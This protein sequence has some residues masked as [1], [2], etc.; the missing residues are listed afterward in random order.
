[1]AFRGEMELTFFWGSSMSQSVQDTKTWFVFLW[2]NVLKEETELALVAHAFN[3]SYSGGGDQEDCNS[4]PA[5]ANSSR[6]TLHKNR[7]GGVAEGEG[8]EFKP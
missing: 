7:A 1:M 6:K 8:P 4:K 3:L 2:Y 5:Q